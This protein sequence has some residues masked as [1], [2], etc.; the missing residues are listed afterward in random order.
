MNAKQNKIFGLENS[1]YILLSS[2]NKE[3]C[4]DDQ[5]EYFY[6]SKNMLLNTFNTKRMNEIKSNL[7]LFDHAVI[8]NKSSGNH[9]FFSFSPV[10]FDYYTLKINNDSVNFKNHNENVENKN[11]I[12][13]KNPFNDKI[14]IHCPY[15][16]ST[17]LISHKKKDD[18]K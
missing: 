14:L 11:L 1:N 16:Y 4:I 5:E 3:Y 9:F 7:K 2:Q 17:Y 15:G 12:Q 13:W 6:Y 18:A 10:G 8:E